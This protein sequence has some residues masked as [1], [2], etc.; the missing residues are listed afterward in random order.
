MIRSLPLLLLAA[1]YPDLSDTL[2]GGP[3]GG[4]AGEGE[5]LIDAFEELVAEAEVHPRMMS[6]GMHARILG[7]PA[8]IR[9]LRAFLDYIRGRSDVWICRRGDLAAHWRE[10]VPPPGGVA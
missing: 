4:G 6:V 3:P 5:L 10:V 9:G 2:R 7:Q 1:C 8:R